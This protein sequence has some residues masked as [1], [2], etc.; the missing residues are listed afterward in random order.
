MRG[1]GKGI[2]LEA[3]GIPVGCRAHTG[4]LAAASAALALALAGTG[5]WL[6]PA[7]AHAAPGA[8]STLVVH[9]DQPF[10]PVTHVASGSLYGLATDTVPSPGVIDAIKPNTF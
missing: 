4:R 9:A 5:W 6:G 2:R 7:P 10:R 8:A 1:R 3:A